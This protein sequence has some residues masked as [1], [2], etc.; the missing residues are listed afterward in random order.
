MALNLQDG[1]MEYLQNVN[2]N[3]FSPNTFKAAVRQS[4]ASADAMSH[5][6]E[7]VSSAVT[8]AAT[9]TAAGISKYASSGI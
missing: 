9:S 2:L 3:G 5:S 8:H 1:G 6:I 7:K 4:V